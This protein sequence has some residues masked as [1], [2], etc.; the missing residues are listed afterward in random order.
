MKLQGYHQDPHVLHAG[1]EENR[2]YYIP[3]LSAEAAFSRNRE[4]SEALHMLSGMWDFAYFD[5]AYDVPDG[6]VSPNFDRSGFAQIPVP[7]VWQVHGY[8]KHQYTNIKYPFPY[9]PPYVP[10]MN[11]CGV[12]TRYFDIGD[13][14]GKRHYVNFEG[15]DSCFYLYINSKLVGYS[16]VSHSTSEFDVT[17]FLIKGQNMIAVVVLKWCDGSYLEDQDKFRQSGIFRDVYILS[18][19]DEHIR[20]YFVKTPINGEKAKIKAEFSFRNKPVEII[21]TLFD[22]TGKEIAKQT[23]DGSTLEFELDE[24]RLWNA[25]H[26]CLYGL[27]IQAAGEFIFQCVGIREIKIENGVILVNNTAVKFRGVNRHDSDPFVG[28]AV[29]MSHVIRDLAIMK[30]HNINAIRTSHYPNSP[31]FAQMCDQY[32][33]YV[34]SEADIEAHGTTTIYGGSQ[35]ETF[36][37]IA[38]NPLFHEAII[39]RVKRNVVRD[40]NCASVIFWSMGNESG[41]GK[42][43]EEAGRWVKEYDPSRLLHYESSIYETGGHKND[44]SM[45]DVYSRM[46]APVD[47]IVNYFESEGGKKPFIQCEYIHAMG[48]G[49]GDAEDYFELIQ[50]YDGFAGGFVWEWCDHAVFMGADENGKDKFFYG[51]DFGEFPHDGNFCMDGLV[52]PNRTPHSGLLEYKNVIRPARAVLEEDG[53][54]ITNMLD[55]TDL[56]NHLFVGYEI[57]HDGKVTDRG[58]FDVHAAPHKSGRVRMELPKI[59]SGNCYLNL[60]YRQ[61]YDSFFTGTGHVMGYEQLVLHEEKPRLPVLAKSAENIEIFESSKEIEVSSPNFRYVFS[62]IAGT[63]SEMSYKNN[64]LLT[65]PM[66]FNIWR[67]PTDNDRNIRHVWQAA[68]YDR[69]GV[70]VYS[71]AAKTENGIAVIECKMAVVAVYVQKIIDVTATWKIDANGAVTASMD[72]VKNMEMPFLPRFGLRL[73]MPKGFENAEYFGFGPNESYVDKRRASFRGPFSSTVKEMHED[74]IKPQENGSRYGCDYVKLYKAGGIS[75]NVTSSE[76]FSFNASHYTQEEL[77]AKAHNFELEECGDTVL[78]LDYIQSGIG[79]N[80]CGPELLEKYRFNDEKFSFNIGLVFEKHVRQ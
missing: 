78:C 36:G 55:F 80:S 67:A 79:S 4:K 29:T 16:Q 15:V 47:D 75:V 5:S 74:Y 68:G 28:A 31:W 42:S 3:C 9:D 64:T 20:D 34:I 7:S 58:T 72:C 77:A 14:A 24:P 23:A 65:K 60:I 37:L 66:E 69:T 26:P 51:G 52:Y 21:G 2:S 39:D 43:F 63:F 27:L 41:Y 35:K 11:P 44:T 48:N 56:Y 32:G 50:K 54:T 6:I 13:P 49:P 71:T 59:E 73:F 25:E 33:F 40:K 46:Y 18:R 62:K 76:R 1:T 22:A 70:K 57:V 30:G 8:D 61:K 19:P 17:D 12:Y 45:L 53:M 38:Q 10:D